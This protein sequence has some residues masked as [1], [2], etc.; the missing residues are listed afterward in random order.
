MPGR[1]VRTSLASLAL[2][3]SIG[4]RRKS[5]PSSSIRSKAHNT[6]LSP[7]RALRMSSK[8]ARPLSSVQIASPSMRN[9]R[10][11]SACSAAT[12]SGKA[13][14]EI[15]A[16][17]CEQS[18]TGTVTPRHD[19]EAVMLEFVQPAR[20]GRR[21]L[22]RRRQTRLDDPQTGAGTLTQRHGGLIGTAEERV[23]SADFP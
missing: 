10:P 22:S 8:T 16:V 3:Y 5:W 15:V 6:A 4:E 13:G 7:C 18:N 2:R 19:T 21:G 14:R 1:G 11:G 23:E 17:A 12:A 9:E 20:A